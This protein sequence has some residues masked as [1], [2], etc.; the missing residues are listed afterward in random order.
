[1][2]NNYK[3]YLFSLSL[4]LLLNILSACSS[5]GS[6]NNSGDSSRDRPLLKESFS[7]NSQKGFSSL[8]E[9]LDKKITI[10]H[11][12]TAC[13][14]CSLFDPEHFEDY[15]RR[16]I[17]EIISQNNLESSSLQKAIRACPT[18]AIAIN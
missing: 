6:D 18:N 8:N 2:N 11:R 4:I 13:G 10:N 12:C 15:G 5:S 7:T 16:V 9:S 1:M 3:K 17:P 14:R